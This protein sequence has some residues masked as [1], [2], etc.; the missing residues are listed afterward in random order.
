MDYDGFSDTSRTEVQN[1]IWVE[2]QFRGASSSFW[3]LVLGSKSVNHWGP[4]RRVTRLGKVVISCCP[5]AISKTLYV[6]VGLWPPPPPPPPPP[7]Q[8]PVD[9]SCMESLVFPIEFDPL[10]NP[11]V[12]YIWRGEA[13]LPCPSL[14][15]ICKIK[16]DLYC[17]RPG[18][19]VFLNSGVGVR[20][21]SC[22]P[23][24][25]LIGYPDRRFGA[26]VRSLA[27]IAIS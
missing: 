20:A 13:A 26:G 12:G 27:E 21:V 2:G 6:S 11:S 17:L 10:S 5:N 9:C 24:M 1:P 3:R 18:Q 14:A 16:V 15:G 25:L 8:G 4:I 19:W 23:L 7:V 22:D